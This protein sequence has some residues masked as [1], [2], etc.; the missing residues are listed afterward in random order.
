MSASSD[1]EP[2][3]PYIFDRPTKADLRREAAK[4]QL[5]GDRGDRERRDDDDPNDERP[6][7]IEWLSLALGLAGA[8]AIGFSL[9]M[10]EL[11]PSAPMYQYLLVQG[12]LQPLSGLAWFIA[13]PQVAWPEKK[14]AAVSRMITFATALVLLQIAFFVRKDFRVGAIALLPPSLCLLMLG[15]NW[16]TRSDRWA[17][18]L[19]RLTFLLP[20][21]VSLLCVLWLAMP[22][23][24]PV[25]EARQMMNGDLWGGLVGI[26]RWILHHVVRPPAS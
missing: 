15:I 7:G 10:P 5:Y 2:R 17:I 20:A 21:F 13:W 22:W 9:A 19:W 14:N 18:W 4:R 3:G 26:L 6:R 24:K 11:G 1:D 12:G 8:A 16:Q 23:P 25:V